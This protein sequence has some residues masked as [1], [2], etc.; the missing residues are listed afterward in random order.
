VQHSTYLIIGGGM[1]AAAAVQG[2]RDLD[3]EGSITM[4]SSE[5]DPPYKRPPLTKGL[6]TGKPLEKVWINVGKHEVDLRLG[7]TV[8][9]LNLHT[10]TAVDDRGDSYTFDKLLLAT[11]SRP[12]HLPNGGEKAIHFRSL[13]DYHRLRELTSRGDHF[14]IV[15][16]G[17]ISSELAASLTANGKQATM[18]VNNSGIGARL[19]PDDLVGYLNDYYRE[20]GVDVRIHEEYTGI[21]ERGDKLL[22]R[23]RDV[24]THEPRELLVD[25]VIAGIGTEPNIELAESAGLHVEDGIIVDEFLRTNCPDVY[26]AGD[27]AAIWQ[28]ELGLRRRVEH[29]DNANSTGRYAGQ[30]MAGETAPYQHMP[31]FYSDLF[32]LGYEAVGEIDAELDMVAGWKTP[33]REGTVYYLRDGI[34]KGVLLWNVWDQVE[35]ARDLIANEVR[36]S[37]SDLSDLLKV[38]A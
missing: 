7:R 10:R 31:F 16:G 17:F 8:S 34:V 18:I 33:H 5:P 19:F 22:L 9:W 3:Q 14:A 11:G 20:Q 21:E 37:S 25:G 36:L 4:V 2:I 30:A 35:S 32:D 27:V 1:T 24:V 6:W 12:R 23:S 29:E 28:P 15:G 26:A 13:H 38:A